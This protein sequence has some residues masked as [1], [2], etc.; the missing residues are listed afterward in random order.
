MNTR[1][2]MVELVSLNDGK[3]SW[4]QLD[5]GLLAR[6]IAGGADVITMVRELIDG[7]FI[8]E[9]TGHN[10]S[11]TLYSVTDKGRKMLTS[12]E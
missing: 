6:G 12:A 8:D 9:S 11:Q 4:Y 10:P 5:R 2:A 7:G 3:W 1:I